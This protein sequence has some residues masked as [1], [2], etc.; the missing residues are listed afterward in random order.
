MN[1]KIATNVDGSWG[2][3]RKD[4]INS[5]LYFQPLHLHPGDDK[6]RTRPEQVA[7]V[8]KAHKWDPRF[9]VSVTEEPILDIVPKHIAVYI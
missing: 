7:L 4:I 2:M 9:W 1:V 6:R 3:T 5:P 8:H